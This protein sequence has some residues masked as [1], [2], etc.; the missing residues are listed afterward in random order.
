MQNIKNG[1]RNREKKERKKE[2]KENREWVKKIRVIFTRE[3]VVCRTA[4]DFLVCFTGEKD[5]VRKKLENFAKKIAFMF[6]I[7]SLQANCAQS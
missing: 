4:N 2:R 3:R 7:I 5:E 6:K 1:N